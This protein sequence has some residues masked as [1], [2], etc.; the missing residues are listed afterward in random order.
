M[1]HPIE[2]STYTL[3]AKRPLNRFGNQEVTGTLLK[4]HFDKIGYGYSSLQTWTELGDASL[5]VELAALKNKTPLLLGA[6]ALQFA[7]TDATARAKNECLYNHLDI[8]NHYS[9]GTVDKIEI[10]SAF[11]CIKIKLDENFKN[12]LKKNEWLKNYKLRIDFNLALV[13][14][15][16]ESLLA[17]LKLFNIDYIEDLGFSTNSVLQFLDQHKTKDCNAVIKPAK[18]SASENYSRVV[19]TS[20]MDHPVNQVHAAIIANNFYK[21]YPNKKEVCG[22]RSDLAFFDNPYFDYFCADTTAIQLQA[23]GNGIGFTSLLEQESW[24][25]LIG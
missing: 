23:D 14:S 9:L 12:T 18:E 10:P 21:K 25:T 22:L 11:Q 16:E 4:V 1:A 5:E 24:K 20:Y 8:Q 2:Y 19:F 3:K 6:K 13:K 7:K 15:T 17:S